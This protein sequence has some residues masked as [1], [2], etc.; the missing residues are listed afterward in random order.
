METI[1]LGDYV[2]IRTGK[3]DA[4]ANDK[5]GKYPFFT[6]SIK[7]LRINSFSY[8]CECVLVAGNGDLNVKYYNGK[9]DAYQRTYIIQTKN[10]NILDTKFLYYCL[11]KY[12]DTLRNQSI[13]GIIKYIKLSN[14]TEAKIILP[15]IDL[16]KRYVEI[17]NLAQTTINKKQQ[18][19]KLLV[20]LE[21]S[22]FIEMFGD[23]FINNKKWKIGKIKDTVVN[24]QYGT[25]KKADLTNG[26][27]PILRMNNI[28][29]KGGWDFTNLK[30]IDI[31]DK[32]VNKYLVKYG[33]VLFNRTNSK[34]LVGKT[35]VY[36]E[37]TP[38]AYAGYLIKLTPNENFNGVFIAMY[39]NSNY[40]K[41]VLYN[42]AKNIVGMAN[43][44]AKELTNINI[45]LP[46]LSLQNE[47][48][49]KIEK[50]EELKKQC[51]KSLEYYEE[52]YETLLH[53]AFNGELFNK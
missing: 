25:S 20:E 49:K 11:S 28:T 26:Q 45:F 5:N 48:A 36:R 17:L 50:I 51:Q 40:V 41:S 21:E 33:E 9:F 13:G 34:E 44:N 22:L 6:C 37:Q 16:Q 18:Q 53:K 1:K 4:N 12:I 10:K 23:P 7:T 2:S 30:Y 31:E 14:L 24:T 19:Y 3:L 52:L 27:Y 42:M 15:N 47:F 43:I 32:D 38:M 8:D 39:L 46:P 29:Y 35:A